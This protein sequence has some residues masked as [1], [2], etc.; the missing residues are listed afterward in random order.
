MLVGR[1]YTG[2]QPLILNPDCVLYQA[3]HSTHKEGAGAQG[4]SV[5]Q[6]GGGQLWEEFRRSLSQWATEAITELSGSP[7][8]LACVE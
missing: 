1:S 2:T 4:I 6:A 8:L 7:S 5:S 3:L